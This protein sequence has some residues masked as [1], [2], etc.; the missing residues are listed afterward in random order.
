MLLNASLR[1]LFSCCNFCVERERVKILIQSG[2]VIVIC[3]FIRHLNDDDV[4]QRILKSLKATLVN[5][6]LLSLSIFKIWA[7]FLFK[8]NIVSF[9]F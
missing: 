2:F 3:L 8:Q 1:H 7:H 4:Q 9:F 6:H 5:H